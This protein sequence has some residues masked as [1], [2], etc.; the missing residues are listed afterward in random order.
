MSDL[1]ATLW[2][3]GLSGAGKSTIAEIVD[4]ELRE[5]GYKVEVLDGDVVRTNLSKGLGFS[6]EDRDT[7]IRRIAFVADLLSRNGVV[8]ITAA[9][10]PY[11][12]IR[13]EARALMGARFIEIHVKASVEECARRDVKGLYEKAMRG[14][15]KEFTG[16]S[17]PYEEPLNPE[18][19]LDTEAESP[20]ESAAKVLAVLDSRVKIAA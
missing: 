19:V 7:N 2:F 3:T 13:D 1:G 5:R 10:S 4:S 11:R 9:I 8:A 15:I 20:E 18:L 12:E 6:K 14:E 17:D 16:V